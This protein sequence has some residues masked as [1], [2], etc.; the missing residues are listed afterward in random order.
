[1]PTLSPRVLPSASRILTIMPDC[2]PPCAADVTPCMEIVAA[3]PAGGAGGPCTLDRSGVWCAAVS[4]CE[5]RCAVR[6]ENQILPPLL[7]AG[8]R[9]LMFLGDS[10][11]R[12]LALGVIQMLVRSAAVARVRPGVRGSRARRERE[13]VHRGVQTLLP[14]VARLADS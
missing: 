3:N 7:A 4:P 9:W 5:S 14:R 2:I 10:D 12:G 1:M 6:W 11:T 13:D 8:H